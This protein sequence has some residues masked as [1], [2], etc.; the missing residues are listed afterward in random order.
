MIPWL[1]VRELHLQCLLLYIPLHYEAYILPSLDQDL[2]M[3]LSDLYKKEYLSLGYSSL[4]RIAR[5]TKFQ[6]AVEQAK[7]VETKTRD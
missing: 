1:N 5:E 3:V 7:T 2:P 4:L 6:L